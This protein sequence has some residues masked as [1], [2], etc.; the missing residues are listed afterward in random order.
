[1]DIQVLH[2]NEQNGK[3]VVTVVAL[4]DSLCSDVPVDLCPCTGLVE[5]RDGLT[6]LV[7]RDNH[8]Q[9]VAVSRVFEADVFAGIPVLA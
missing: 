5:H 4:N 2:E 7:L 9:L 1:M 8:G 3:A 6:F